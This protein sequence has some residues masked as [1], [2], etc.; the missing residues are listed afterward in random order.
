MKA[1]DCPKFDKCNA[2]VCPLS[3]IATAHLRGEPICF[4]LRE[5]VKQGGKARLRG[6]V[7]GKMLDR[8]DVVLPEILARHGDIR[9]RLNIS[10]QTGSKINALR[11]SRRAAA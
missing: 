4:Y 2:P 1:C 9:R 5:Y 7:S 8:L 6:Y 3:D 11:G 10:A